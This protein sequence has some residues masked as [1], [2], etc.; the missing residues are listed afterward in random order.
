[1][2]DVTA[3]YP[4]CASGTRGRRGGPRA[5]MRRAPARWLTAEE[6]ILLPTPLAQGEQIEQ[7]LRTGS[8]DVWRSWAA[9]S[10]RVLMLERTP[11][12]F[13]TEEVPWWAITA[14]EVEPDGE[15][16]LVRLWGLGRRFTLYDAP[17]REA[18]VFESAVQLRESG[19]AVDEAAS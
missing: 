10:A 6:R 11:R 7:V 13:R 19:S 16:A 4:S 12:A 18:R 15:L 3:P 5:P 9:T 8:P 17:L 14:V 2:F 1:M